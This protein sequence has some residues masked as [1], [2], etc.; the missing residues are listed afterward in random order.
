MEDLIKKAFLII[1]LFNFFWP[2]IEIKD[3]VFH[4]A[5]NS[6]N[7]TLLIHSNNLHQN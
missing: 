1:L 3:D 5:P 2:K 6:L 4:L 7:F